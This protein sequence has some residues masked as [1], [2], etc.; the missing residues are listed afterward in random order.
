ML[1]SAIWVWILS[2]S[3]VMQRHSCLPAD[4]H[5]PSSPTL[6]CN[7]AIIRIDTIAHAW[8]MKALCKV[9]TWRPLQPS[10][11]QYKYGSTTNGNRDSCLK[12]L[13]LEASWSGW[14]GRHCGILSAA[15]VQGLT[16]SAGTFLQPDRLSLSLTVVLPDREYNWSVLCYVRL[17]GMP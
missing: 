10:L 7:N 3:T 11:E 6:L 13:A 9:A 14:Q 17:P 8:P 5:C 16:Q 2:E 4:V 12:P 15:S 1:I